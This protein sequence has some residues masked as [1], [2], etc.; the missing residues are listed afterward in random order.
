MKKKAL[1][2]LAALLGTQLAYAECELADRT[3][4]SFSDCTPDVTENGRHYIDIFKFDFQRFDDNLPVFKG[5]PKDQE[6]A[7]IT[8]RRL[9]DVFGF[10]SG[11]Y[12]DDGEW[13]RSEDEV[14]CAI[15]QNGTFCAIG[16][17]RYE[18]PAFH[19]KRGQLYV[20]RD[21]YC[22][23]HNEPTQ[24]CSNPIDVSVLSEGGIY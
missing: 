18:A 24:F 14:S 5:Q 3:T 19:F 15:Y 2:L 16:D 7:M 9:T 10:S 23:V 12:M 13:H 1:I 22:M 21:Y 8:G 4:L 20:D 6:T 17:E 11:I